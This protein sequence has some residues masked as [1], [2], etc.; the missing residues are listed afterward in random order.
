MREESTSAETWGK[1]SIAAMISVLFI[2]HGGRE[3]SFRRVNQLNSSSAEPQCFCRGRRQ[4]KGTCRSCRHRQS[5]GG[6]MRMVCCQSEAFKC[7]VCCRCVSHRGR[8]T[9]EALPPQWS[10]LLTHKHQHLSHKLGL[11]CVY[12]VPDSL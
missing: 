9:L 2:M 12:V 8:P 11:L 5:E 4:K 7:F 6:G 1:I 10:L 3:M